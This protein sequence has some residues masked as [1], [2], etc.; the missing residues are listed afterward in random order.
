[1]SMGA[2]KDIRLVYDKRCPVCEF[3]CQRIDI[4][5]SRGRLVRVDA[6]ASSDIMTE[7]T[8]LG[9]DIDEGMVLQAGNTLYYGCD[10][11][12]ALALLSSRSGIFNRVAFWVFRS[13]R[14]SRA[15][16]PALR[17]CRNLLLRMLRRTRI[18]NL[19]LAGNDRF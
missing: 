16:Y 13:R 2:Q 18:N 15:L 3:Y 11:I 8:N 14:V 9:L 7:I 12:N 1:M 6:R 19:Q 10:A 5:E 17:A 4:D